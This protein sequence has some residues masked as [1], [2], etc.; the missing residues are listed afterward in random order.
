M[1]FGLKVQDGKIEEILQRLQQAQRTI[2]QCYREL[3]ELGVVVVE[4]ERTASGN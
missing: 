1:P 3:E 2:Y 4:K